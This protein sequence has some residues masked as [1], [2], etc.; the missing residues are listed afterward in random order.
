MRRT[1]LWLPVILWAAMIL[2]AS[3]D[4]FS[5]TQS[6]GWLER[7]F[8]H[9]MPHALNVAVRKCGHL[10]VYGILGALAWRA[11]RRVAIA[12]VVVAMVAIADEYS[13]GLTRTRSGS[14]WD[15]LL[16]LTGAAIAVWVVRRF[17]V[18]HDG[19]PG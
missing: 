2:S 16:D 14:P 13:Q 4:S 10:L 7:I 9:A 15:V 6:A 18:R 5:A 17:V 19:V 12:M 1:W 3:N 11:E 8:G